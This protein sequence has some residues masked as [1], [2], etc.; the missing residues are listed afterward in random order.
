MDVGIGLPNS[1]IGARGP[2]L[3]DWARRAERNG[4]SVLGT[5]GR[6]VYD[7][8]EELVSL[9]AAAGATD[10]IELMTTVLVAPP[11]QPVLLAKQAATLSRVSG[12][13][14]RLGLGLGPREDDWLALGVEPTD[15]GKRMDEVID[16]CRA[17]W[18]GEPPLGVE[19]RVGPPPEHL[20]LVLSGSSESAYRRAGQKADAF[21]AGPVPPE[22]VGQA[23]QAVT[24]AAE[25]AGRPTPKLYAA[26]YAAL[27]DDASDEADRNLA[28][29]YGSAGDAFVSVMRQNVLRTPTQ[30]Q[31]TLTALE[32]QGCQELCLW[33]L[34]TGAAQVD[35]LAEAALS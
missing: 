33:P 34:A 27:G 30:V 9:A 23:F 35:R 10:R 24:N 7:T 16:T 25:Q 11:R 2:D 1:L 26:R 20:P 17:I 28:S 15:R 12:G 21:L 22:S 31:E 13:R 29:Y 3:V 5:I 6:I 19:G 8:D 18:A 14:F 4:F 32:Q